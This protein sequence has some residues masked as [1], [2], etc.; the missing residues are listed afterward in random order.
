MDQFTKIERILAELHGLEM[1]SPMEI[2][3]AVS[4]A[5]GL[6]IARNSQRI[7]GH[8]AHMVRAGVIVGHS[9]GGYI[10]CG[11]AEADKS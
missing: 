6:D 2:R 8:I 5:T 1:F 7:A 9:N 11:I 3:R 10:R 4:R